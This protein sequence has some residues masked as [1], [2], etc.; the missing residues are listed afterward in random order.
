MPPTFASPSAAAKLGAGPHRST[1]RLTGPL[2]SL[3]QLP[4]SSDRSTS[5]MTPTT[6]MDSPGLHVGINAA[7]PRVHPPT[8]RQEL[9]RL[10][11]LR[12]RGP[13]EGP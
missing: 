1:M 5:G 12:P 7:A 6:P 13:F 9:M 11:P 8:A 2:P 4:C 10:P 3:M